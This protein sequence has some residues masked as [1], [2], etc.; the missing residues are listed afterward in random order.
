MKWEE[1]EKEYKGE[2]VFVEVTKTNE[3]Y[4]ILEAKVLC[5]APDEEALLKE[6]KNFHPK[7]LAIRYIGD[8]PSDWAVMV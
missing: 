4:D 3:D 7:A 6:S 8:V 1:I 2:W 5:H